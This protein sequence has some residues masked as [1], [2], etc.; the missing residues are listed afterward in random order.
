MDLIDFFAGNGSVWR[1]AKSLGWDTI[2]TD[3][4]PFDGVDIVED[5][6]TLDLSKLPK[7]RVLWFSPPCQ[8]F[9][10]AS[11]SK[12]WTGGKNAYV[13]KSEAAKLSIRIINRVW[14]I[15]DTMKPEYWYIENPRGVL[16]KLT[17]MERAPIRQTV[18]YCQYGDTRMKP[19]DIWTNNPNWQPRPM[20]KNGDPC[21]ERAPRGA[22]TGTQGL[23]G[24]MERSAIPRDLIVEI[25]EASK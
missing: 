21:H 19:T 13:P 11:I 22:K 17:A 5:V 8:S 12:H 20:C 18:T 4:R 7:A 10:V 9:S 14:E 16:R 3:I 23:T 15:I 6:F 24:A 25:L 1:T 2:S